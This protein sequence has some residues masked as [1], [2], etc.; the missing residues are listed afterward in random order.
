MLTLKRYDLIDHILF[1][2]P[3]VNATPVDHVLSWIFVTIIDELQGI[4]KEHGI[5]TCQI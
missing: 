2:A 4:T 3:P 1:D 5:T